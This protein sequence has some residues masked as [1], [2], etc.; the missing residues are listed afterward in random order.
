MPVLARGTRVRHT[1]T[2]EVGT[3][4]LG[5]APLPGWTDQPGGSVNV[6][7]DRPAR[8]CSPQRDEPAQLFQPMPI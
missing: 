5:N 6:R 1:V 8:G 3:V 2:G 4:E 7:F